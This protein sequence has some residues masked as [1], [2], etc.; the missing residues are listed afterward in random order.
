[1]Y[2]IYEGKK[3]RP[4]VDEFDRIMEEVRGRHLSSFPREL[5]GARP[6]LSGGDRYAEPPPRIAR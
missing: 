6:T 1:M 5:T 2:R 4:A 3:M